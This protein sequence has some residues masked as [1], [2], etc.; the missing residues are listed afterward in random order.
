M[1]KF[2]VLIVDD[3]PLVRLALREYISLASAHIEVAYEA[4]DGIEAVD[5]LK[6]RNDIDIVI[7]DIQ[8]PRMNGVE[9]LA[10]ISE[11]D[12]LLSKPLTIMLSAY[13]DFHYVRNSFIN[14]AFDYML[15]EKL[16][17]DYIAPILNKTIDE[18]KRRKITSR[19]DNSA[20]EAETEE[21]LCSVLHQLAVS[22]LTDPAEVDQ[23]DELKHGVTLVQKHLGEK[24]QVAAI[25]RLSQPIQFEHIHKMIVQ[26]I[27][28]VTSSSR[29]EGRSCICRHDERHYSLFFTFP[30]QC[31]D[32]AIRNLTHTVLTD[33]KIRMRRFL[34]LELSIGISDVANGCMHWNRLFRQAE[35]LST[36]SYYYGYDH[37]LYPESDRSHSFEE[38]TWK[39][40]WTTLKSELLL[41]LK[42][43]DAM[44]YNQ[45]LHVCFE[46][47]IDRFPASP[48]SIKLALGEIVWEAGSLIHHNRITWEKLHK[49]FPHPTEHIRYVET[50]A[51]TVLWINQFLQTIHELL[52]PKYPQADSGLS[53]VVAKAKTILDSHYGEDIH[54]S[55][56][57]AMVGVS[58]SY[59]SKQ[60]AKEMGINFI[61]YLTN[62]RIERAKEALEN[63]MK[64][65]D[66]A[67]KVGYVNP[68]HFSRIFKKVT[69]V[70]PLTYRKEYEKRGII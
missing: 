69:G 40:D 27:R 12:T 66:V 9:L 51:D 26:T 7:A 53:S 50:W 38:E 2:K 4:G 23:D 14:G 41:A 68:E 54:L 29:N 13:S 42:E 45:Q 34:N 52:H 47:L 15:K 22:S 46:R 35:R 70:S 67:E 21:K 10:S 48:E 28:T 39:E 61:T 65:Y 33:V 62:L 6:R 19:P 59:L 3:E 63:G 64:I 49:K 57:S 56:T 8:M 43:A 30:K 37:L 60:F 36:L 31:S 44:L 5:C 32:M 24:N 55:N 18:L 25:I 17:E 16:D 58:E 20:A 1:T 11:D